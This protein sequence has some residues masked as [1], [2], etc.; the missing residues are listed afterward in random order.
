MYF[1]I[2]DNFAKKSKFSKKLEQ[3]N[4]KLANLDGLINVA[5]ANSIRITSNATLKDFCG[6]TKLINGGGLTGNFSVSSN[7]YNPTMQDIMDGNC[8]KR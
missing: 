1:Y 3:I 8:M 5:G 6:L 7:G 4:I 2:C